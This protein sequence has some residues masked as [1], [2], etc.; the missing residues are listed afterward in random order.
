MESQAWTALLT[1]SQMSSKVAIGSDIG[2]ARRAVEQLRMEAGINRIKVRVGLGLGW[3]QMGKEAGG[4]PNVA[5]LV[6]RCPRQLQIC[7][8]S[9]QNRP[10]AT[11]SLS[12]S[13][14]PPT[15]S[16]KRSPVLSYE[17]MIMLIPL[18]PFLWKPQEGPQ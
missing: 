18:W 14:L 16:R 2:Q 3:A 4:H 11:P 10:R 13:Q 6:C 12:A 5:D 9:A 1:F 17:P 7:C 8:S 15:L